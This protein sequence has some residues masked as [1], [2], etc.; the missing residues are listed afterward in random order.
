M[1]NIDIRMKTLL[2]LKIPSLVQIDERTASMRINS[3]WDVKITI[4]EKKIIYEARSEGKTYDIEKDIGVPDDVKAVI[5]GLKG[6]YTPALLA[7]MDDETDYSE[8]EKDPIN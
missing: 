7:L 5:E 2:D 1:N 6:K 4:Q 8:Q 3:N